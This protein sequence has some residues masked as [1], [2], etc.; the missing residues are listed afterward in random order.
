MPTM[1][2]AATSDRPAPAPEGS[3]RPGLSRKD[4]RLV[5]VMRWVGRL[6]RAVLRVTRGRIGAGWFGGSDVV[7]LTVRGRTSGRLFTVPLMGLRDG[8]DLLV[9]ASQGGVDREPQWWLNLL[10]DPHAE[11]EVR[12]ERFAVTAERVGDEERPALWARF[13]AAYAGFEDYQ[14]RV[15]RQ[16]A[17]VRLR[18]A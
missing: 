1:T 3:A 9:A 16:I 14:A 17:V 18:R 12:R 5:G 6:H 11:V 7:L 10:A 8:D 4:R 15:T 13:V 2:S